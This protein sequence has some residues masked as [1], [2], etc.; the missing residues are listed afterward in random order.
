MQDLN[1]LE[2]QTELPALWL[3]PLHTRD[4][5]SPSPRRPAVSQPTDMQALAEVAT[6]AVQKFSAAFGFRDRRWRNEHRVSISGQG[7]KIH[8]LA[9]AD[10][11]G[12]WPIPLRFS[13]VTH[14]QTQ[15]GT[16]FLLIGLRK[17]SEDRSH[18][19]IADFDRPIEEYWVVGISSSDEDLPEP[20]DALRTLLTTMGALGAVRSDLNHSYD[21]ADKTIGI[22]GC[23]SVY[24]G[25][26]RDPAAARKKE[27]AKDE[28]GV[29]AVKFLTAESSSLAA[30][31]AG[32]LMGSTRHRNIIGFHGL[33]KVPDPALEKAWRWV[34]MMEYCSG[35]DLNDFL[36]ANGPCSE[37]R[38]AEIMFGLLSALSHLHSQGIVH[39][40]VKSENILL[41]DQGRP[42]LADFGIAAFLD[43]AEAMTKRCGSPGHC[44]PEILE[45]Q[46]YNAKVD[47]FSSGVVLYF[48]LSGSLPFRGPDISSV[49]RR[50]ARCKVQLDGAHFGLVSSKSKSLIK[51]FL[52]KHHEDRP[53][54]S[55][56]L[57]QVIASYAT[58][59]RATS[60]L[61]SDPESAEPADRKAEKKVT[62]S[63]GARLTFMSH[64]STTASQLDTEDF[65][66]WRQSFSSCGRAS[67]ASYTSGYMRASQASQLDNDDVCP[68]RP[69]Y[70]S[71]RGTY[72]SRTSGYTQASEDA[73]CASDGQRLSY[74][75]DLIMTDVLATG[76]KVEA[77][78]VEKGMQSQVMN[79]RRLPAVAGNDS[80]VSGRPG[81][82]EGD[83]SGQPMWRS[84]GQDV[85][86]KQPNMETTLRRKLQTFSVSSDGKMKK[87]Q[88]SEGRTIKYQQRLES[89]ETGSPNHAEGPD[90]QVDGDNS[91]PGFGLMPHAP[92]L[93]AMK[94]VSRRLRF[95][96]R[97]HQIEKYK[98][99]STLA[100]DKHGF[101][102]SSC[103]IEVH[104][105][106]GEEAS[107]AS[108]SERPSESWYSDVSC[109]PSAK[110]THSGYHDNDCDDRRRPSLDDDILDEALL[111]EMPKEL[112]FA[113]DG[114]LEFPSSDASQS[115]LKFPKP[116]LP[117]GMRGWWQQRSTAGKTGA[118]RQFRPAFASALSSPRDDTTEDGTTARD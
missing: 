43:D 60:L 111:Q 94:R 118:K 91:A 93:D 31:E 26:A 96:K 63:D 88:S 57:Q 116:S 77:A 41:M 56:A 7:L 1:P 82:D 46:K 64:A 73:S 15:V 76:V 107:A 115:K 39:R 59:L 18:P 23:S 19:Q 48:L 87:Y 36:A 51:S 95:L 62:C 16:M 109:R 4:G 40:D 102:P 50:T 79:R 89:L 113:Q 67:S 85:L 106:D 100:A 58:H 114:V 47:V 29:V 53:E 90:H 49:L 5:S 78:A 84:Q 104:E 13:E 61:N 2:S 28:D 24:L 20:K 42:V 72:A 12:A 30:K 3:H 99:N 110:S 105:V 66:R 44:A 117:R 54:S 8:A 37:L 108:E 9:D 25:R 10:A 98:Q 38:S 27:I 34:V 74:C 55:A 92:P 81:L 6:T 80:D 45:S 69:S 103:G 97:R 52:R 112:S 32:F 68:G 33:F 75:E 17:T 14:F 35:G 83:H 21:V 70:S 101:V 22:G 65:L 86:D 11:E 71:N